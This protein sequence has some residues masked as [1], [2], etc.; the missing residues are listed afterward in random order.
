M[1]NPGRRDI[2]DMLRICFWPART[3]AVQRRPRAWR[4]KRGAASARQP[5]AGC[6][7]S[8]S[9]PFAKGG[10]KNG[11]PKSRGSDKADCRQC[12][13][14][15]TDCNHGDPQRHVIDDLVPFGSHHILQNLVHP[16]LLSI[17]RPWPV[18]VSN[19]V[20]FLIRTSAEKVHNDFRKVL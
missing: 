14:Y 3:P 2:R 8:W 7:H 10:R 5:A 4:R 1:G 16:P 13:E 11:A 20:C 9:H 17:R 12:P 15:E 18:F 19:D 6:A